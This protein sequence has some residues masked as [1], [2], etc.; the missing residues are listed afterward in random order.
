MTDI[1]SM[2]T[3]EEMPIHKICSVKYHGIFF[4]CFHDENN[5]F[6]VSFVKSDHPGQGRLTNFL[7]EFENKYQFIFLCV[8]NE[9]FGEYLERRGYVPQDWYENTNYIGSKPQ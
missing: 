4:T 9:C 3:F 7:N 5:T 1:I 8:V 6:V 2:K